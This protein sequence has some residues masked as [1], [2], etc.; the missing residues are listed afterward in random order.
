MIH[1]L[2]ESSTDKDLRPA[3][4]GKS[5]ATNKRKSLTDRRVW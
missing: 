1:L 3:A 2:A 5:Q 4:D